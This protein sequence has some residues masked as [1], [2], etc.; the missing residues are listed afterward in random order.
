MLILYYLWSIVVDTFLFF[1][2][3]S[4]RILY[5]PVMKVDV[6]GW[7]FLTGY[8]VFGVWWYPLTG[9]S[10]WTP[11]SGAISAGIF[12]IVAMTFGILFKKDRLFRKGWSAAFN[13]QAKNGL[14]KAVADINED[15]R[16]KVQMLVGLSE[17]EARCIFFTKTAFYLTLPIDKTFGL[18]F[19][20]SETTAEVGKLFRYFRVRP[21]VKLKTKSLGKTAAYIYDA[22]PAVLLAVTSIINSHQP[23][24]AAGKFK[25]ILAPIA[26]ATGM[27]LA[28]TFGLWRITTIT[29]AEPKYPIGVINTDRV[30]L[31]ELPATGSRI[32]ANLSRGEEVLLLKSTDN[33]YFVINASEQTGYV[34]KASINAK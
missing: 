19:P 32:L 17:P 14:A 30:V 29:R 18:E 4:F 27:I 2:G 13:G 22:D 3:V 8:A 10:Q 25:K 21:A 12:L 31:Y 15:K 7:L 28:F 9:Q 6:L 11:L 24:V 34:A 1:R 16:A 26:V 23:Q 33:Y 5:I 20:Y